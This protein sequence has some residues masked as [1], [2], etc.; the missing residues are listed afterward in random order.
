MTYAF[1]IYIILNG[2]ITFSG[3]ICRSMPEI[4]GRK[5]QKR[6]FHTASLIGT[7]MVIFGGCCEN[8]KCLK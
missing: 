3:L 2:I 6:R 4:T 1:W 5:P 8:Y 7:K